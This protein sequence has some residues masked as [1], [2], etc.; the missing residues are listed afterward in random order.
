MAQLAAFDRGAELGA[1]AMEAVRWLGVRAIL[2][3]ACSEVV[4]GTSADGRRWSLWEHSWALAGF[5]KSG[6]AGAILAGCWPESH[7]LSWCTLEIGLTHPQPGDLD[8]IRDLV[9]V[10]YPLGD[11]LHRSDV[12]IQFAFPEL[13]SVTATSLLDALRSEITRVVGRRTEPQITLDRHRG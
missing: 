9:E 4:V 12:T 2:Q 7:L 11:E 1:E 3:W 8:R 13:A 6:V 5:Y 10:E